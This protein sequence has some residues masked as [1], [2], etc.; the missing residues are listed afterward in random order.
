MPSAPAGKFGGPPRLVP[1]GAGMAVSSSTFCV[2][3]RS[4]QR[5]AVALFASILDIIRAP[6]LKLSSELPL[7]QWDMSPNFIV[8]DTLA[9]RSNVSFL[10]RPNHF[11][12]NRPKQN[13][14]TA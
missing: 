4:I 5:R 12:S 8:V 10:Q 11:V 6:L 3:I 7:T 9:R 2:L 13:L 14:Q 1:G